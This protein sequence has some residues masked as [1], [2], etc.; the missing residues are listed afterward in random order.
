MQRALAAGGD[1]WVSTTRLRGQTYLRAGFM[2]PMT[3]EDDLDRTLEL[4]TG[5]G[6]EG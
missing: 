6:A 4:V 2:N 5:L 1:A 3:T